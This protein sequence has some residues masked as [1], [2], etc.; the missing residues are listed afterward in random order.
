MSVQMFR[1]SLPESL[2]H[3]ARDARLPARPAAG[4]RNMFNLHEADEP[5]RWRGEGCASETERMLA[6][7]AQRMMGA[8]P[9]EAPSPFP[10]GYTYLAQFVA[11]DMQFS[12]EEAEYPP[13]SVPDVALRRRRLMLETIYGEGPEREPGLY[14]AGDDAFAR[15]RLRY[16]AFGP[17]VSPGQRTLARMGGASGQTL[18]A[19]DIR[20]DENPVVA[21]VAGAFIRLHNVAMRRLTDYA[22]PEAR[23]EAARRVTR[24]VYR[25]LV[26]GDLLPRLLRP[27]VAAAYAGGLRLDSP[28][29]ETD[30]MP[31]EFSHAAFRTGHALVRADYAI[32]PAVN[33]GMAINVR[34]MIR[35]TTRRDPDAFAEGRAWP[36]DWSRFFGPSA[37]GAQPF[38]PHVNV[39]LAEAP[40]L[41]DDDYP[42]KRGAHLILRDLVRGM[43]AGLLNVAALGAAI[44]PGF[45]GTPGAKEWLAFDAAARGKAMLDWIDGETT[46]KPYLANLCS[47]PPLYLFLMVEAA[48]PAAVGGGDRARYGVMGGAIVAEPL[49]AAR[50]ATLRD[51]EEVS[52]LDNDIAKVFGDDGG[53]PR[54]AEMSQLLAR[55][56]R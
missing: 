46:L 45:G 52:G 51:V 10:A 12:T 8:R 7:V 33:G 18:C 5:E 14:Q 26:F 38:G 11:H 9:S 50:D 1:R 30:D 20:N 31:V 43:D 13:G 22:E 53:S 23:F 4:F 3:D 34:S 27:D 29:L 49:H 15:F 39:F 44:A 21:Q 47:D 25:G 16:G 24:A 54:P 48:A 2:R 55:L 19:A 37:Q 42:R 36:L 17:G 35:H 28:A 32:G 6:A 56:T 40:G 41:L